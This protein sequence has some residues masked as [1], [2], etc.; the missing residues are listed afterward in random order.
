MAQS[1]FIVHVPAHVTI[2]APFMPPEAVTRTVL[3]QAQVALSEVPAFSF[4]LSRVGRFPATAYLVPEPDAPFIALTRSLVRKFPE[5]PPFG[6]EFDSIVPHLTVAHG[7][8]SEAETV[9]VELAAAMNAYAPIKSHCASV[10]L[11]ENSSGIW[12]QMH[13]FALPHA[14]RDA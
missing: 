10:L 2:L 8:A 9:A 3:E 13:A 4:C 12:K 6:G 7:S 14:F 11:L 5:Y 1:A